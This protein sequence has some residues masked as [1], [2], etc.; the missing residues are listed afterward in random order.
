MSWAQAQDAAR[1]DAEPS[2]ERGGVLRWS[3]ATVAALLL[4]GVIA[5]LAWSVLA[6]PP[7]YTVRAEGA[8]MGEAAAGEQFG[9]EVVYTA[10][11]LAFGLVVGAVTGFR[12]ARYGWVLAVALV[13]GALGAAFLSLEVGRLLGPPDPTQIVGDAPAGAVVPIPLDVNAPGVLLAWPIATLLGLL[14]VATATGRRS[15][16]RRSS[17]ADG[18]GRPLRRSQD[19]AS[20]TPSNTAPTTLP[21]TPSSTVSTTLPHRDL[22]DTDGR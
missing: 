10:L 6:E 11:A 16:D 22:T 18:G 20:A 12:L 14:A 15:A 7:G 17:A 3:L 13:I 5:G 4:A 9:V 19:T 1:G 8:S 2:Y 21:A